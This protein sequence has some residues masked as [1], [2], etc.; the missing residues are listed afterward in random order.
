MRT[1]PRVMPA[2]VTPFDAG[3]EI[4]LAAHRHNVRFLWERNVAGFLLA[5][6]T[7]EGPYLEAGE[8]RS[9]LTTARDELG[10]GAFL[11]CGVSAETVR[12]AASQIDEAQAGGADAVLVLTPTTLVRGRHHLVEAF[13]G[14]IADRSPLPL[15]L[16]TVPPVTGYELP[17]DAVIRLSRH[18]RVQGIKDSGGNPDRIAAWSADVGDGFFTY[19][20][21]SRAVTASMAAG[22]YGAITASANY[23]SDLVAR[24]V[25]GDAAAQDELRAVAAAVESD[26]VPGTKAAAERF[27]LRCGACRRPLRR[28]P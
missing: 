6:S 4:D 1:P 11:L 10:D 23:A 20:G 17:V 12:A 22:G 3:E 27:G 7:G 16:Y 18:D 8:R 26:G 24:A 25:D 15:L 2:L 9:L 19:C 21:A 28:L 13:F 14:E 5:G